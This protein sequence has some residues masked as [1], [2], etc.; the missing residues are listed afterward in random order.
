MSERTNERSG[1]RERSERVSGR[2]S[3]PVLASG[4]QEILNH[5]EIKKSSILEKFETEDFFGDDKEQ[6]EKE[7]S[8]A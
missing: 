6:A 2:A 5:A 1:A 3:G 4:F 8:T 7:E